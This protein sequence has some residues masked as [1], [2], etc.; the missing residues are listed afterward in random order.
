M[1][2]HFALR[3]AA[4]A[5]TVLR[6]PK[7]PSSLLQASSHS[8]P[9]LPVDMVFRFFPRWTRDKVRFFYWYYL[10]SF[11]TGLGIL[12]GYFHTP[13]VGDNYDHFAETPLYLWTKSSLAK[14]GQLEENLRVKVHHFYPQT[15]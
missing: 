5:A 1:V 15:E 8:M 3:R 9:Y 12:M 13:Y 7:M 2:L 14:T 11:L 10:V 6:V 4:T